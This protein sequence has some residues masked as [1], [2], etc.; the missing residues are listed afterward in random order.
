M[1]KVPYV[2]EFLALLAAAAWSAGVILFRKMGD[3]VSAIGL[4]LFKNCVTVALLIVTML[5]LGEPL[6]P[7]RP[8]TDWVLLAVSGTLGISVADTLFFVALSRLGAGMIAVVD[9]LYSPAVIAFSI[10]F[11]GERVGLGVL[12]GGV[13]VAAAILVGAAGRPPEGRTRGDI[14]LGVACGVIAILC[15]AGGIVMVKEILQTAPLVWA[16]CVRMSAGLLGLLPL[17]I[18]PSVRRSVAPLFRPR[19]EWRLAIPASVLGA[20][21]SMTAWLGGFKFTLASVAAILNQLST[22]F[23]FVLAAVFLGES[24]SLRRTLAV[25]MAVAGALLV[26]LR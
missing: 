4:N 12:V 15:M 19:G 13:L 14:S 9:T 2:G 25:I 8:A 3:D 7:E 10:A 24:M 6:V 18:A 5:V 20:Y 21:V 17:M 1:T 26:A 11:L 16:A 23:I 22:I